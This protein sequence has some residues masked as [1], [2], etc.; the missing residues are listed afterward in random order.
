MQNSEVILQANELEKI[1]RRYTMELSKRRLI[2][3]GLDVLAPD[4]GSGQV[5]MGF[6]EDM[7]TM[8][9]GT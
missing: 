4:Y 3:P 5:E 6:I 2:G 1:V 9:T 7:Y 8:I